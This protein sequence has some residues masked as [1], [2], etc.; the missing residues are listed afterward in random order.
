VIVHGLGGVGKTQLAIGYLHRHREDYPDGRFWLRADQAATLI[1]DLASLAWL[2]ELPERE[3]LEHELQIEAVLRWLRGHDRWLLVLDNLDQQVVETM[4]HWLPPD[5]PGH[6]II[7][8]R[9]PQGSVRLGLEP[10]PIAVSSDFLLRRRGKDD[11]AAA[12]AIAET[13]GGLPLALEQA[14]A[15]LIENPWRG[16][17]DYASLLQSRMAELLREGKP[18]DYPLPVASTWDLSFQRIEQKQPAAADLLRLCAFL[19]PDDIPVT[20]LKAGGGELPDGLRSALEDEIASDRVVGA[21]HDY[22]LIDRQDDGLRVHRL[23]QWMVR[24]SLDTG[25]REQWMGTAI[26]L[27]GS[28][29][30]GQVEEPAEW[31]LCARLLPHAQAAFGL[32]EEE[33]AAAAEPE[34]TSWLLD[35]V[36]CYLRTRAD[37]ALARPLLERALTINDR[38]LG[39]DHP[40][41]ATGLNNLGLLL[42][43]L[44]QLEAARPYLERA[45]AIWEKVLGPD[46]PYTALGHNNLGLLLRDLGPLEAARPYLERALAIRE[47]VLGPDH[48][49]TATSLNN[50]GLLLRGLG[51]LEAARPYLERAL[52]IREKVLGPNHPDTAWSL[53]N[54]GWLLRGLGQLEAARPYLERALTIWEK[55]LGPDHPNTAYGL[56]NLGW[57]LR[58]LGQL[59]A[60][61]PYLERALAIREKVLGPDHP[62][63]ATS[64]NNLGWLLQGLGQREA[65]RPYLERALAIWEKVLGPDHPTTAAARRAIESISP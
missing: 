11:T 47:K 4:R 41:T 36:G 44:G 17:A 55:V 29:F 5:L 42:Q 10:L 25:Q 18:D 54:L 9:S 65:A 15:Y 22:S 13:V 34:A 21:L 2:L 64:L 24:E 43:D 12:R 57:L 51:Q 62:T 27:L 33:A 48:P 28:V 30:P 35:A 3:L 58:G 14:A 52:A 53:T 40:T 60:A 50:L 37:Y 31:P 59:E 63:T 32:S 39:P 38:V 8:S 7:T 16:L 20:A 45:L 23:V 19:A 61:R 6:M 26:R 46:H 1:S 49:D 56:N